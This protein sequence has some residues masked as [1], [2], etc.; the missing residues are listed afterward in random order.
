MANLCKL[1]EM[2]DSR[3]V[4]GGPSVEELMLN[5]VQMGKTQVFVRCLGTQVTVTVLADSRPF[6][7]IEVRSL[8]LDVDPVTCAQLGRGTKGRR[9]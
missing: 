5:G 9:V 7:S 8:E 6:R 4:H 2:S 3:V 1:H